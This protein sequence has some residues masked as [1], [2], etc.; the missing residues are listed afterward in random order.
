LSGSKITAVKNPT[1]SQNKYL[2][3]SEEDNRLTGGSHG[4]VINGYQGND[5]LTGALGIDTVYG[6]SGNDTFVVNLTGAGGLEDSIRENSDAGIDTLQLAG[7]SG[8]ST[9]VK[10][11]L[12]SNLENLN[13]YNTGNSKLN[14]TGN[15]AD[16]VIKG[17]AA[18]NVI[19]GAAG[20][21]SLYGHEGNDTLIGGEGKDFLVGGAGEDVYDFNSLQEMGANRLTCDVI[22]GFSS[23]DKIDLSTLDANTAVSN[24][25]A[26]NSEMTFGNGFSGKF[27]TGPGTLYFDTKNKVLYGNV[28]GDAAP[29]FAIQILGAQTLTRMD[30][31]F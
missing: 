9:A 15:Q 14:L 27:S 17:N 30:V 24:N 4:D 1:F 3:G 2:F 29:E 8:N 13:A 22:S 16:N 11:T 28:D 26:F 7:T 5:V 6:G 19:V 25:Q 12:A 20:N 23:G 10:I 18:N 31:V 21:D